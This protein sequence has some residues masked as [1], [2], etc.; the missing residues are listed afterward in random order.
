MKK[1]IIAVVALMLIGGAAVYIYKAR[2]AA[3][4]AAMPAPAVTQLTAPATMADVAM[5]A[6]AES[7][8]SAID[9]N[10]YDLTGW[11]AEHPGGE[12]AILSLCGKDG[13]AAFH[14]QHRDNKVQA[15]VLAEFK[16]GTVAQ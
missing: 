6:G 4:Y 2:E 15:D 16:I 11:V 8:W 14:G 12:R 7:C 1:I 3:E 5:H 13:T 10:V 9:G